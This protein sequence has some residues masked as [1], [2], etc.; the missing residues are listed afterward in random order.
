M[1]VIFVTVLRCLYTSWLFLCRGQ[2]DCV[3][4]QHQSMAAKGN[5][6]PGLIAPSTDSNHDNAN[7]FSVSQNASLDQGSSSSSGGVT[8]NPA[9]LSANLAVDQTQSVRAAIDS[10][11]ETCLAGGSD[12]ASSSTAKAESELDPKAVEVITVPDEDGSNDANCG[13]G[14]QGSTSVGDEGGGKKT[15]R[16][17]EGGEGLS[18][19]ALGCAPEKQ[20]ESVLTRKEPE[21]GGQ[22]VGKNDSCEGSLSQAVSQTSHNKDKTSDSP[23]AVSVHSSSRANSDS[24][25]A[26]HSVNSSSGSEVPHSRDTNDSS[27][28]SNEGDGM[29]SMRLKTIIDRVLDNSLGGGLDV[30]P[31]PSEQRILSQIAAEEHS[32]ARA[33]QSSETKDTTGGD[34]DSNKAAGEAKSDRRMEPVAICFMEHIEKAVERSFSSITEEE[35]RKEKEKAL[36]SHTSKDGENKQVNWGQWVSKQSETPASSAP[37][38]SEGTAISVQDIVDRVISQTEVISKLMTTSTGPSL[39]T[40]SK[41]LVSASG[42]FYPDR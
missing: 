34:T 20:P 42:T 10:F 22:Q 37:S 27:N 21:T 3:M 41:P 25:F 32:S 31:V 15:L 1:A 17:Q 38:V 30:K 18:S 19:N 23:Q 8:N 26:A 9:S 12:E 11:I 28:S 16:G 14:E 13:S 7:R 39:H 4:G 24:N 40:D 6:I 2:R 36:V 29:P 33:L 5:A 35:E